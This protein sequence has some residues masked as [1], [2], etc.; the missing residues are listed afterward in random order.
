MAVIGD[1]ERIK[2]K[3]HHFSLQNTSIWKHGGSKMPII[4]QKPLI[5]RTLDHHIT[6]I[7]LGPNIIG[8]V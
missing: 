2:K 8:V 6:V 1:D 3:G 5:Y 4:T 7:L